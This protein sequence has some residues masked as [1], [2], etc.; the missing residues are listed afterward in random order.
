MTALYKIAGDY[1][2]LMDSDMSPEDMRDTL[3]GVKGTI[4]DK[5]EASLAVCKNKRAYADA[6]KAESSSLAARAKTEEAQIERLHQY[7]AECMKTADMKSITAGLH[8][9]TL[10][11]PTNTVSVLDASKIPAEY[12]DFETTIKP[13]TLDIRKQLEAGKEIPGVKLSTGKASLLIK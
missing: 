11:K 3:E 2:K 1:A 8:K 4:E 10:R 13:H 7:I 5:I 6:L 12:V 9:V